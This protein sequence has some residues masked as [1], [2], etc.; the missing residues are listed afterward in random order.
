[1]N[2]PVTELIKRD[3]RIEYGESDGQP[4][5]ALVLFAPHPTGNPDDWAKAK[6]FFNER[7]KSLGNSGRLKLNPDTGHLVRT[8]GSCVFCTMLQIGPCDYK[9]EIQPLTTPPG[10]LAD[11]PIEAPDKPVQ[12]ALLAEFMATLQRE[13]GG[14]DAADD[15][16]VR[17]TAKLAEE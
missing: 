7:M 10:L 16:D 8:M 12:N 11:A 6:P 17:D 1:M 15:F 5:E 4:L 14:W 13:P 9:D 3:I 2:E